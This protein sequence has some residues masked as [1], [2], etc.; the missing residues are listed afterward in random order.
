MCIFAL[1]ITNN[2][3]QHADTISEKMKATINI[4]NPTT[5]NQQ[6]SL[7]G[8]REMLCQ[9]RMTALNPSIK[10]E[11]RRKVTVMTTDATLQQPAAHYTSF[12]LRQMN[13]ER[14]IA[15]FNAG[16]CQKASLI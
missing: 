1:S 9:R 5:G 3:E 14:A 7:N 16:G 8:L 12:Q 15:L 11:L 10:K 2:A 13:A 4:W 6:V